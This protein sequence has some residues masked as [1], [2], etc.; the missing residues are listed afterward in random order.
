MGELEFVFE[1]RVEVSAGQELGAGPRGL[2]RIVPIT[3]GTFEGP[4]L[5]GVI[6]P[7]GSDWQVI[8]P[9]GVAELEARYTLRVADGTLIS[10]VNRALRHG[11]PE[12]MA[13][14]RRGETVDPE[15]YYLRTTPTFVAPEGP[16]DW[17]CRS[18]FVG[19]GARHPAEVRIRVFRVP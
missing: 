17:L 3:G 2:R 12:V 16:H 11:P 18:I 1:A 9:D 14:L 8:R 5:S 13:R 19:T 6:M 10:V 7:G 15:S 4:R